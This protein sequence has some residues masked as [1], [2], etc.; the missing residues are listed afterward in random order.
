M[1]GVWLRRRP[2]RVRRRDGLRRTGG[3]AAACGRRVRLPARRLRS[4]RGVSHRL[5]VVHR[6]F[7]RRDRRQRRR[8]SPTTSAGSFRPRRRAPLLRPIPASLVIR[9]VDRGA[10][11]IVALTLV[12][13]RGLGPGRLVQNM[14]AGVKVDARSS[15]SSRSAS[16]SARRRRAPDAP[17]A[18]PS[19][20]VGWLLAL[21]PV[22]FSY[23]GWNA[24]A[25]V[26]EEVRDPGAQRAARAGARHGDGGGPLRA[27][28]TRSMSLRCRSREL[29]ALPGG[30]LMDTVA[31]RLFGFAAGNLLALFT[32]VSIAASISAMVLA[33]PR[34]YFAMA[35]DGMFV[36]S[37]A[38]VHPRF[39]TPAVAIVAQGVW[40]SVLVLSGTLVAAR[41]LHRL[42]GRALFAGS[43]SARCSCCAAAM[44][45]R[46]G[47]S[48]RSGIRGR[49]RSSCVASAV[50][51]GERDLAERRHRRSPA[52]RSSPRVFRCTTRSRR[53]PASVSSGER[54][55]AGR[56][57]QERRRASAERNSRQENDRPRSLQ[58]RAH[59]PRDTTARPADRDTASS[60]R[61]RWQAE[62]ARSGRRTPAGSRRR[63]AEEH[64]RAIRDASSRKRPTATS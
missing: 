13:V 60:S 35:R 12:H 28:S 22:M 63:N 23:S 64:S 43:R 52:S 26:A 58:P 47:R 46:R 4:A 2:A 17:R 15:C 10:D 8:R 59:E 27:R 56:K 61:C 31:E 54:A 48:P 44:P 9:R 21:V 40:S 30:R 49:R 25:Y 33:G 5:D 20:I 34:V 11:A 1:L 55:V 53:A 39:H 62:R 50:D 37:A 36:R 24:A 38:R 7:L 41:E 29:A 18:A 6:R 32:I 19:P 51:G 16:R 42:C 3:G 57:Q 45:A 14:L